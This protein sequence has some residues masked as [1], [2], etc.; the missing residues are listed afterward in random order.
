MASRA[1]S[2]VALSFSFTS[3]TKELMESK[4]PEQDGLHLRKAVC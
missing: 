2:S 4:Q 1:P 3:P